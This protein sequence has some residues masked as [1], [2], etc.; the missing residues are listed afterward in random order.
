M[1]GRGKMR[2]MGW[3]EV[4]VAQAG[5]DVTW[6]GRGGSGSISSTVFG[7]VARHSHPPT[8]ALSVPLNTHCFI[9]LAAFW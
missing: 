2:Q 9:H 8:P 5:R 7:A 3:W 6:R 4:K 1:W